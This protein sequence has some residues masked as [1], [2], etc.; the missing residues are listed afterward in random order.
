MKPKIISISIV[1]CLISACDV[2]NS[3]KPKKFNPHVNGIWGNTGLVD[4]LDSTG[5][6]KNQL[7]STSYLSIDYPYLH[8]CYDRYNSNKDSIDIKAKEDL[9]VAHLEGNTYKVKII[10]GESV[11]SDSSTF[12]MKKDSTGLLIITKRLYG[13]L[14]GVPYKASGD[15]SAY[16]SNLGYGKCRKNAIDSTGI[17]F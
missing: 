16:L 4:I 2:T 14:R 11:N 6:Y 9:K 7:W 13:E 10:N 8:A 15:M 12:K 17:L 1:L 5:N 3:K